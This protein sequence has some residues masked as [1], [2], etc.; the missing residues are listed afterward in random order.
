MVSYQIQFAA[1]GGWIL[2]GT[3]GEH[4]TVRAT[5]P[6][7]ETA[8]TVAAPASPVRT[9]VNAPKRTAVFSPELA[10]SAGLSLTAVYDMACQVAAFA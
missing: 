8:L 2:E 9:V 5:S 6:L 10:L 1:D 4:V 3:E 7:S